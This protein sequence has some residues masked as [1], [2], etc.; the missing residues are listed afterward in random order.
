MNGLWYKASSCLYDVSMTDF[1]AITEL[2]KASKTIA[3]IGASGDPSRPSHSIMAYLQRAGF[4]CVPVNPNESEILGERCYATLADIPSDIQIDIANVFRRPAHTPE[5]AKA[6]VARG[7][8]KGL[9]LQQG[10]VNDEAM[11]IAQDGNLL[12]IQ[13][14]CIA[15][16]HRTMAP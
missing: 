5:V 16:I 11:K 2:L 4:K 12:T 14:A 1:F 10:I 7:G 13:D 8:V 9:W 6:A 15:V 3:I